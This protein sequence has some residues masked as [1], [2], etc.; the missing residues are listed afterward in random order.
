MVI[1]ESS[2]GFIKAATEGAELELQEVLLAVEER[3]Q[4]SVHVLGRK[5]R[6]QA[7]ETPVKPPLS[8]QN[9]A[10]MAQPEVVPEQSSNE[11]SK[12]SQPEPSSNPEPEQSADSTVQP[13]A[14]ASLPNGRQHADA[15]TAD[16][17]S[18]N[19]VAQQLLSSGPDS[20]QQKF[21]LIHDIWAFK[22]AQACFASSGCIVKS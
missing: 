3:R 18:R 2:I 11:P 12:T 15:A 1:S 17:P 13:S 9:D 6:S 10:E 22:R 14:L 8:E 4:L 5:E 20:Q 7:P 19:E 21:T 16:D